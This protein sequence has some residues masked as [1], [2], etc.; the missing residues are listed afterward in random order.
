MPPKTTFFWPKP[1]TGLVVRELLGADAGR[2]APA[3]PARG[4][5]LS[6]LSG[7]SQTRPAR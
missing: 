2:A 3:L 1:R 6:P 7:N 5:F 4:Q